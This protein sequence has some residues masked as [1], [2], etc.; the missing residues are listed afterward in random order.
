MRYL[1]PS[2]VVAAALGCG[3][4]SADDTADTAVQPTTGGT[5]GDATAPAGDTAGAE[6]V[7]TEGE[8]YGLSNGRRLSETLVTG[9]Q[10]DDATLERA[11]EA[12]VTTVISLRQPSEPGFEEEKAKVEALGMTFVSIPVAGA[13]G[14]TEENASAVDQALEEADGEVM[15]HCG[16]GNRVGALLALRAFHVDDASAEEALTLG[17]EAGLTRLEDVVRQHFEAWCGEHADAPQC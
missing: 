10:P 8:A 17:R 2:L 15:L 9:G 7:S 6:D 5:S 11:A 3:G 13:E 14:V 4:S 16:S 12:G 1:L